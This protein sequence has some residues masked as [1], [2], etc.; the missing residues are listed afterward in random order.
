[1]KKPTN[2]Q[3]IWKL[4][5]N[6]LV[7]KNWSS[8]AI[9]RRHMIEAAQEI[10]IAFRSK[11]WKTIIV[12]VLQHHWSTVIHFESTLQQ[13]LR[14]RKKRKTV[15]QTTHDLNHQRAIGKKET[16]TSL[17]K[18]KEITQVILIPLTSFSIIKFWFPLGT[19]S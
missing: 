18:P 6:N 16:K 5:K 12:Y 15:K 7:R 13:K 3:T 2:K 1:M 9:I 8:M 10:H 4:Y 11:I 17:K 14:K 19:N